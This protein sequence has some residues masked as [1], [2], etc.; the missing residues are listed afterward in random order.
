VNYIKEVLATGKINN[1]TYIARKK[2][3]DTIMDAHG[4]VTS[5]N[6]V[7]Y[8]GTH[9]CVHPA[10]RSTNVHHSQIEAFLH[11]EG[12]TEERAVS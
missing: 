1:F 10:R 2:S 4:R 12:Y 8:K 7:T 9:C 3:L 5:I 6:A 11:K